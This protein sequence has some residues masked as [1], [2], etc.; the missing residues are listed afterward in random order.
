MRPLLAIVLAFSVHAAALAQYPDYWGAAYS[1]G[2]AEAQAYQR[3]AM[4]MQMQARAGGGYGYYGGYSNNYG[5]G[6][7]YSYPTPYQAENGDYRNVDNDFD[8]RL[9]PNHVRGYYRQNGTY[10]RGHYRA[11]RGW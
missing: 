8:G 2:L 1:A 9:E 5:Y 10:T 7:G 3:A 6:Q 4:Q 11:D